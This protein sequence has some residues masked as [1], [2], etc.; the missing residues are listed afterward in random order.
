MVDLDYH[1]LESYNSFPLLRVVVVAVVVVVFVVVAAAAA[2]SLKQGNIDVDDEASTSR[3]RSLL[4]DEEKKSIDIHHSPW[5][6]F[7]SSSASSSSSSYFC[8]PIESP[9][10][11]GDLP[12]IASWLLNI[13][14]LLQCHVCNCRSSNN[15]PGT[16]K[17]GWS[18]TSQ[19][20]M[21]VIPI[22]AVQT[23]WWVTLMMLSARR[24]WGN[25]VRQA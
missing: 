7:L 19:P 14:F 18:P 24:R 4:S 2:V 22:C 1:L 13:P 15:F 21:Y 23:A 6:N 10:G 12:W 16:K 17:I 20:I 25:N 5:V 8:D 11:R 9:M 3:H